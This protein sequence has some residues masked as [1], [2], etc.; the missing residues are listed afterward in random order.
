MEKLHLAYIAGF[1]DGEGTVR[2]NRSHNKARGIRYE[3][4]VCAVN[5]CPEPLFL[6]QKQFGG[7][8]YLRKLLPRHKNIYCWTLGQ[9]AGVN[10][11]KQILPYLIIKKSRAELAIE[12]MDAIQGHKNG[13]KL[14]EE[15]IELR[16]IYF[17]RMKQL[18][19]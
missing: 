4:Q 7:G 18:N 8:V 16:R 3:L 19:Q 10:L 12:F 17:E 15:D 11:L 14:L 5:T 2:I 9:R 13:V 6:L 1:L